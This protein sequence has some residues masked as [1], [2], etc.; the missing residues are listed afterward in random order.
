MVSIQGFGARNLTI[1]EQ[2]MRSFESAVN[3]ITGSKT[4]YISSPYRSDLL[5]HAKRNYADEIIHLWMLYANQ[6]KQELRRHFFTTD[7]KKDTLEGFF[8]RLVYLSCNRYWFDKYVQQLRTKLNELPG[9]RI[10]SELNEC[11]QFMKNDG[12]HRMFEFKLEEKPPPMIVPWLMADVS[13]T[14]LADCGMN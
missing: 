5:Y 10:I 8:V 1:P 12:I 6:Q 9:Y 7:S 2:R 14:Y 11:Q 4:L 13:R 3:A